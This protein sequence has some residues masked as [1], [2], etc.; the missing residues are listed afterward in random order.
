MAKPTKRGFDSYRYS[1]DL[2]SGDVLDAVER[3]AHG[4]LLIRELEIF[5]DRPAGRIDGVLVPVRIFNPRVGRA[6]NGGWWA[7]DRRIVGIEVKVSRSDFLAGLKKDQYKKYAECVGGLYIATTPGVC[8]TAEIPD[9]CG[10]IIVRRR[11]Y[12]MESTA[13]CRRHAKLNDRQLPPEMFWKILCRTWE[14]HL[15]ETRKWEKQRR[16][17]ADR[18]GQVV[19]DVI[20]TVIDP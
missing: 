9:G 6:K 4:A 5:G 13:V 12:P 1:D 8:K 3:W 17:L 7:S 18:A 2:G 19:A 10:H 15:D 20:R 16:A 11:D 14:H